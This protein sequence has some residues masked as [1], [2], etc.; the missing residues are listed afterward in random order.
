ME[1][2]VDVKPQVMEIHSDQW[3]DDLVTFACFFNKCCVLRGS[4]AGLVHAFARRNVL[5][6]VFDVSGFVWF[7]ICLLCAC[8]CL[9]CHCHAESL[10]CA[11]NVEI[12]AAWILFVILLH[13]VLLAATLDAQCFASVMHIK[14]VRDARVVVIADFMHRAA[15]SMLTSLNRC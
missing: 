15:C 4:A 12:A 2:V 8:D 7:C 11:V 6:H 5:P 10:T 14:F 9:Q 1:V 13:A 3:F